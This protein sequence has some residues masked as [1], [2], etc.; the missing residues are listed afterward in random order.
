VWNPDLV[1]VNKYREQWQVVPDNAI[2]DNGFKA[3]WE[4]FIKFVEGDG[5]HPYDFM[6]GA[7]G[8]ALAEAGLKSSAEGRRIEL[9]AL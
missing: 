5:S 9:G 4:Q 2:F 8:V 3:Q 6:A 7:R 1:E